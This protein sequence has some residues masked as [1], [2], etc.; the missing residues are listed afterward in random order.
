MA[1][2]LARAPHRGTGGVTFACCGA[3]VRRCAGGTEGHVG[4]SGL[5]L[6]CGRGARWPGAGSSHGSKLP[7]RAEFTWI[8]E[9]I[10]GCAI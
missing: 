1:N 5:I 3:F 2:L 10:G 8:R 9:A 6:G 4:A 7:E